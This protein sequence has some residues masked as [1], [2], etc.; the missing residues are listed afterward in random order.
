MSAILL[1]DPPITEGFPLWGGLTYFGA[2]TKLGMRLPEP[3]ASRPQAWTCSMFEQIIYWTKQLS[4]A[5]LDAITAEPRV[6]AGRA[7]MIVCSKWFGLAEYAQTRI[8]Q[9][10]WALEVPENRVKWGLDLDAI[11]KRLHRWRRVLPGYQRMAADTFPDRRAANALGGAAREESMIS[12]LI[13]DFDKVVDSL[14]DLQKRTERVI[15]LA[16]ALVGIAESKKALQQSRDVARLTYL[17]FIF[18]PL[19]WAT[20]IFSMQPDL[21]DLGRTVWIYFASAGSLSVILFAVVFL[22]RSPRFPRIGTT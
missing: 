3:E 7:L 9:L 5:E 10:E 2:P 20:G 15:A 12:P 4:D 11:V 1:V 16:T 8:T 21:G 17:A 19:Q 22:W 18:I 6:L 13:H 14:N